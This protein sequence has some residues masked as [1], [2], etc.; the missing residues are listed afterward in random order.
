MHDVGTGGAGLGIAEAAEHLAQRAVLLRRQLRD[1]LHAPA[2]A[3]L[4]HRQP[5]PT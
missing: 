3:H 1:I 4:Q 5:R 2:P